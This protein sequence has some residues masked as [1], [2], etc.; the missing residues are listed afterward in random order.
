MEEEEMA[1]VD[2]SIYYIPAL[3][4]FKSKKIIQLKEKTHLEQISK[5]NLFFAICI[6]C[7]PFINTKIFAS[8]IKIILFLNQSWALS[9]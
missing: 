9:S 8:G 3:S 7:Y 1:R 5:Y 2:K 4:K 6:N